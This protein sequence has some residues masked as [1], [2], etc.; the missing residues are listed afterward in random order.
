MP[1]IKYLD[2]DFPEP[3]SCKGLPLRNIN[4]LLSPSHRWSGVSNLWHSWYKCTLS[5]GDNA[6]PCRATQDGR[7][8]VESSDKTW[9]TGE[10]NGKAHPHSCLENPMNSWCC[11]VAQ[12][13]LLF[14]TPWTAAFQ[15]PLSFTIS[16]SLLK[17][18]S[19]ESV[20]PSKHLIFCRPLL[21]LP[22]I[23]PSIRVFSNESVLC[24]RWPNYWSFSFS[25]SPSNEYSGLTSIRVDRFVFL[26]VQGTQE[27]SPV[28]Q[29]ES[30]T[31][32]VFSLLY[33]ETLMSIHYSVYQIIF[34]D[35]M[36]M[37]LISVIYILSPSIH[38][39]KWK[40]FNAIFHTLI[41]F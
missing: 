19:I 15:V 37:E 39:L 32:S 4:I 9:S 33:G 5:S 8:T 17:L 22:S 34:A 21:L 1:E 35:L 18:I 6:V 41:F 23:F 10:G 14:A 25:I 28:P 13:C 40:L 11:L 24:I 20:I 36:M 12:W 30:I 31:S 7:S 16:Q 26:A 2:P 3:V 27:S 29:F 38:K